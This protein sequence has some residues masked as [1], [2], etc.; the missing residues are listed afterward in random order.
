MG[1]LFGGGGGDVPMPT[2]IFKV[3]K[4]TGQDLTGR[5]L[6]GVNRYYQNVL[7]SF[8]G[9]QG[10]Y[11]PQFMQQGFNFGGQALTGLMGLQ[12]QAGAGAAQQK[13]ASNG[14]P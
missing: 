8:L 9:L 10:Q 14:H 11:T 5:Q 6:A 4:K 12:Q 13:R 3:N 2:D 1:S 7:P